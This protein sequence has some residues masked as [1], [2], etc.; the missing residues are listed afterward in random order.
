MEEFSQEPQIPS[1]DETTEGTQ[2]GANK[3]DLSRVQN[4]AAA[5]RRELAKVVVGQSELVELLTVT[6]FC[7]GHVLLEGVPGIAKTLSAKLLAK[8]IHAEF[9]RIQ[10]T[11]DLMPSDVVGTMV[12]NTKTSDFYFNEG[13]IFSNIVL[14]DEINRAPAKTQSALFE[15]MEERQ[16]TVDGKTYP[17]T[18]PFFVI[19]TQNPIE[20]EGTYKLPEAQLDRF[21]FKINITYPSLAEEQ[22]ILRLFKEDFRQTKTAEVNAVLTGDDIKAC[23]GLIERVHIREELLDYIAAIV[24]NTRNNGDIYLGASPRASLAILKTS[25]AVAAMAGRD[26]VIPEDIQF[27]AFPVLNHRIIL[28]PEREMEGYA[29]RDVIAEIIKKIDVPR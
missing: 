29:T 6:V 4:A 26:F 2:W 8:T 20:Q 3:L 5:I 24:H 9:G 7:E 18:Y 11:P 14:I 15:V 1:T 23:Q 21:M 17:M 28:S 16:V 10:F 27:V 25:K 13:P 12:F 19:A 22:R